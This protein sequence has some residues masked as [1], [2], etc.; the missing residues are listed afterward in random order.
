MDTNI[1]FY[2][3]PVISL[4]FALILVPIFR[5]LATLLSLVD[6]PN[7][8]KVHTNAVPLIGGIVV[9]FAAGLALLFTVDFWGN[10]KEN[11]SL[12]FGSLILL[13]VG[14]VDDKIDVRASFKFIIQIALAYFV[15][16]SGIRIDS[17]YGIFGI[18]ELPILI[19]YGLTMVVIVG[20]VNAF[21]LMDGIDGL[22]AGLAIVGLSAFTYIAYITGNSFLII[23]YLALI[24]ALIGFL[25]FNLFSKK[26]IFMGDAGSL[27]L[28][29]VL[30]VS[31][32]VLIQSAQPTE[33]ITLALAVVV[34]VLVLPVADSLRV[35]RKRIKTGYSPFRADKTHLHHLA[36]YLGIK[37][38]WASFLIIMFSIIIVSIS[39]FF[40][41][42]FSMTYTIL[43][44]LLIFLIFSTILGINREINIWREK[45]KKLEDF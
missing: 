10:V 26:K 30:V 17:M 20:V 25:R 8:R 44:L 14:V 4:V 12:I 32:I 35:Y 19:Q 36:L 13:V 22:A 6:K 24:G 15:F 1:A 23:L 37:H 39:I 28:G 7:A 18:Y 43:A 27:V 11:Y 9:V 38:K 5:R 31:G 33:N 21:N 45:I 3:I 2:V 40:G 34:G 42:V 41:S 29:Y 16:D